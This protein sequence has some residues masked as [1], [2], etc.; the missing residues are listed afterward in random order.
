MCICTII[1]GMRIFVQNTINGKVI[2]L[3]Q[4]LSSNTIEN[5]K[6]RIQCEEGIP[7]DQQLFIFDGKQLEDGHTLSDYNIQEES[8]LE[9]VILL[10][11]GMHSMPVFS[12]SLPFHDGLICCRRHANICEDSNRKDHHSGGGDLVHHCDCEGYDSRQRKNSTRS[13]ATYFCWETAGG[14]M[15]IERLQHTEGINATLSITS[16][17]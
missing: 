17:W 9:L 8:L 16:A 1:G 5:V 6:A 2:T 14:W 3:E 11:M 10:Q 15:Y 4:V 13:T 7:P 12:R